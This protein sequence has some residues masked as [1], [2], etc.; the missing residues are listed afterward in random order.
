MAGRGRVMPAA[1]SGSVRGRDGKTSRGRDCKTSGS[2]F[3]IAEKS[4]KRVSDGERP[5]RPSPAG[6]GETVTRRR[7][8][9]TA[10]D[11]QA[12]RPRRK[13]QTNNLT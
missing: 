7:R 4:K 6:E 12:V 1:P 3:L 10:G 8:P 13:V 2:R 9:R 5:R 11:G